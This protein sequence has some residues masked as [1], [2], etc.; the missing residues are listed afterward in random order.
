MVVAQEVTALIS[1]RDDAGVSV[2]PDREIR[3]CL[4]RCYPL[5]PQYPGGQVPIS[6]TR[7]SRRVA[8]GRQGLPPRVGLR[9]VLPR[10]LPVDKDIEYLTDVLCAGAVIIRSPFTSLMITVECHTRATRL[11]QMGT[12]FRPIRLSRAI[13][14]P[15]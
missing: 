12:P 4:L 15:L 8:V 6:T 13:L 5:F 7:P 11:C 3:E 1:G 14:Q 2:P 9:R 10:H